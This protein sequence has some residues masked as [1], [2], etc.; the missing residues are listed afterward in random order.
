MV[1]NDSGKVN[2]NQ[3][4]SNE[5]T[6]KTL[7]NW[8]W[9]AS[10]VI[11]GEID[12]SKYKEYIIPLIFLKR[13]SDV[14][15]DEVKKINEDH[16]DK[17]DIEEF[18]QSNRASIRFY[19]PKKARWDTISKQRTN[20]GE[21]LTNALRMIA[22]ENPPL[23][24]VIDIVDFN[25]T[26]TGQRII[27]ERRL[28]S[29]IDVLGRYHL[30]LENVDPDILGRAYEFLL[31]KFAEGSGQSGGEFFTPMEVATL[32]A[33]ILDPQP[34][35]EIY[36]PT[37]GTGGLLIKAHQRFKEDKIDKAAFQPIKL[38]GQEINPTTYS[39]A[40]I[41]ALIH[42][43]ELEIAM[44]DTMS[45]PMFLEENGSLRT[46]TKVTANP[47]WNQKF[48]QSLYENDAYKRFYLGNPP[49]SSGDWGWIQHMYAS[50]NENGKMAIILDTGAVS[51]GSGAQG[52]HRERKFRKKFVE[53]D[54]VEA[55]IL[56]PEKLFYNTAAAAIVLVVNKM[57]KFKGY[58]LMINAAKLFHKD[59][60]Q[61]ILKNNTIRKIHEVYTKWIEKT[62]LSK[63]ISLEEVAKYDYNLS[64]SLYVAIDQI[65][66]I[67]SPQ[68]AL[69]RLKKAK[70]ECTKAENELKETL[71]QLGLEL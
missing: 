18:F 49:T 4:G 59:R 8:L 11:R 64:P 9:E 62:G 34:G 37:C 60:S 23:R 46:F 5:L 13:L 12:S 71:T 69:I 21:Y 53:Q 16:I 47:P 52:T 19:I 27:S 55:V 25:V 68:E 40:K 26:T 56:L 24:G 17:R 70:D 45:H 48:P 30:G 44:G 1:F 10:C 28:K 58:M 51:R 3:S 22:Q 35:E 2:K 7:A 42:D 33:F 6:E 29:L 50:L 57:K 36:D 31:K 15:N 14:F 63:I 43:I 20:L 32:M 41:N 65:D 67:L 38:F 61:N 54:L 39:M 66:E